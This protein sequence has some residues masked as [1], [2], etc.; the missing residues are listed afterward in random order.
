MTII[1]NSYYSIYGL[2]INTSWQFRDYN[3]LNYERTQ[4][5]N[6]CNAPTISVFCDVKIYRDDPFNQG[7]MLG[8][9]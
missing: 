2:L 4:I 8:N 7:E 6:V 5:Q 1:N 3:N 9:L